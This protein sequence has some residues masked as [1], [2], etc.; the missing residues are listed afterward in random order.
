M[1]KLD[2]GEL[3]ITF[4]RVGGDNNIVTKALTVSSTVTSANWFVDGNVEV[5]MGEVQNMP[6]PD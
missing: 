4:N 2:I 5:R 3:E 1:K 6:A